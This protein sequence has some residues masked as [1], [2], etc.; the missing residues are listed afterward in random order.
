VCEIGQIGDLHH[1]T[2]ATAG[3]SILTAGVDSRP[4]D[5]TVSGVN[6]Q[7]KAENYPNDKTADIKLGHDSLQER[8]KD[9][10]R[11]IFMGRVDTITTPKILTISVYAKTVMNSARLSASGSIL[12]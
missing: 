4:A 5:G 1:G 7:A 12:S 8:Q 2:V 11:M 9:F 3:G 6:L 10:A